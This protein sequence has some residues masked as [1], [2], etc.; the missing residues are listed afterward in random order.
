[1]TRNETKERMTKKR[2]HQDTTLTLAPHGGSGAGGAAQD[3]T[4]SRSWRYF[5]FLVDL[6]AQWCSHSLQI[7]VGVSQVRSWIVVVAL[8]PQRG[9]GGDLCGSHVAVSVT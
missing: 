4:A 2:A 9:Q 8:E 6:G 5:G 7:Q 3:A 1:M